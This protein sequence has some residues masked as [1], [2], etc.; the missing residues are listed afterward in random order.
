[1]AA[2]R[3]GVNHPRPLAT[4]DGPAVAR[5]SA[6]RTAVARRLSSLEGAGRGRT[7]GVGAPVPADADSAGAAPAAKTGRR[8]AGFETDLWACPRVARMLNALP[9]P[10]PTAGCVR[11]D[12]IEATPPRS[13]P[14]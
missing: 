8:A 11:E 12:E 14:Q 13:V 1:M 7:V 6:L 5:G 2:D 10:P 9:G 4:P 3:H